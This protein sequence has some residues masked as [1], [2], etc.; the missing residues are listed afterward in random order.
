MIF[1]IIEISHSDKTL[2]ENPY[3]KKFQ[4]ARKD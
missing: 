1:G 3:Q 4:E 2:R